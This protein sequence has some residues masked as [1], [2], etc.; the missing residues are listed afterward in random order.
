MRYFC[1]LFDRN[2]LVRGLSLIESLNK[3]E[4][5]GY[6]L[7]VVCLDELTRIL[8][9]E[10]RLENVVPIP[11]HGIEQ[12]DLGLCEAK[13]N[14]SLVE[15]YWT[16]TPCI[17]LWLLKKNR[18]IDL[19]T[20]VDADM[21]F[22]SSPAPLF[23]E[24]GTSSI[25]IHEHRFSPN[26]AHL[27]MEMFGRYNVGMIVFR[28]DAVGLRVLKKWREQCLHWCYQ[29]VEDGKFGDQ[30]YLND[31]PERYENI[32]VLQHVG[33]GVA[34]WNHDQYIFNN[35]GNQVL[36]DGNPLIF[37]HFHSLLMFSS[38]IIVPVGYP[39]YN[40]V[41]QDVLELCVVPYVNSLVEGLSRIRKILS[42]FSFGLQ[43]G[44]PVPSDR[45]VL[46]RGP[47][48]DEL[49]RLAKANRYEMIEIFLE[50][51]NWFTLFFDLGNPYVN[52]DVLA[53]QKNSKVF[54]LRHDKYSKCRS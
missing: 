16:L 46:C 36:V 40:P 48:L 54:C 12:G 3:H 28:N 30:L 33:G 11:L 13:K 39:Q 21:Y 24:M 10:I 1:T 2:Y 35:L 25:M 27:D 6:V 34:P 4:P 52:R 23:E 5:E 29:K 37:Y 14:R 45:T 22:F 53:Q 42:G 31:W 17:V 26:L 47:S 18:E 49:R 41:R 8:L 20:Y 44:T 51:E 38:D 7:Y 15:Y 9:E 32:H 19:I 50:K 43:S